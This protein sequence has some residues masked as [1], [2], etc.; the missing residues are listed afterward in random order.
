MN[1]SNYTVRRATLDDI[2]PL[3]ELWKSMKFPAEGM[4]KRIT[5]FQI[6]TDKSGQ[7]LGGL[8]LQIAERQ[9]LI[10]SDAFVDFSLAEQLRPL[11]WE[12]IHSVATNHGLSRL[13]TQEKAPFWNHCGMI[14][15]EPEVLA[16]LPV[17]WRGTAEG[18][19][20]LKLKED[21]E[22]VVSM[23]KE[24][25][26]F[27]DSEKQR[28]QRAFQQAKILKVIVTLIA[29][30]LFGLVIAGVFLMARKNPQLLGR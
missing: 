10:H 21:V 30:A 18:W 20:T 4:S 6:A 12:R 9:G 22:T 17:P 1:S 26:L 13:W 14:K 28:T 8:G 2:G 11:L 15:A 7:L 23:D 3:T 29:L 5:E 27:M 24:F 16:K 19:L 25:A